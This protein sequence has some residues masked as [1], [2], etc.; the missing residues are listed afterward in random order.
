MNRMLIACV[1]V[2]AASS[3]ATA[4][5]A[6]PICADRPG[7]STPTCTVPPGMVQVESAIADWGHDRSGGIEIDG[8]VIGDSAV[9][10]GLTDRLHIEFDA[11]P[12]VRVRT[13]E[14]G[15]SDSVSGFGDVGIAAKYRL[16]GDN[17]PVELALYPFVKIPT[18]KEPIG[19]GKIEGGLLVP[20]GYAIPGS[21]LSLTFGP[22]LDFVADGDGSGHH[23]AMAQ[24]VSLGVPLWERLSASAELW[25]AWD[26]DPSG[27]VKQYGAAG[28]AAFLVSNDVQIDAGAII[29]L[30][31]ATPDLEVYSGIAF[32][33]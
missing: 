33:F 2:C 30:N 22:E 29:G 3:A 25:G 1:S 9:K 18:A 7:V 5:D 21:S 4:A 31:R 16:T 28:S 32:R 14:A 17:A 26:W 27:T 11:T 6:D 23:L 13:R 20:I 15:S 12:Y 24:V 10:F 8:L 19:N